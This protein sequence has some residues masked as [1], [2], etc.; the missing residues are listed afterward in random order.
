MPRQ[1]PVK[2]PAAVGA[3]VKTIGA[4]HFSFSDLEHL[5]PA[6]VDLLGVAIARAFFWMRICQESGVRHCR[7]PGW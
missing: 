6:A 2:M 3:A 5:Q 7:L 4:G 1:S